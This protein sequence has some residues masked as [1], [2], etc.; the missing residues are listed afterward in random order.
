MTQIFNDDV[1][2]NGNVQV[3]GVVSQ[4][5]TAPS[6]SD[7]SWVHQGD[8]TASQ[9]V[10]GIH[11]HAPGK[12]TD[13]VRILKKA[14]PTA[15][16]TVTAH[17]E[18]LIHQIPHQAAGVL[19]RSSSSGRHVNFGITNSGTYGFSLIHSRWNSY[20]NWANNIFGLTV[21]A[22]ISW[23]RLEDDGTDRNCYVSIDGENWLLISSTANTDHITPDEVGF[24]VTPT[25]DS[26]TTLPDAAILVTTW[27]EA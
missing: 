13:Y 20:T 7:F 16:Y 5:T 23:F 18:M 14:A 8:A 15:P 4:Q 27:E 9:T 26:N 19:W 3:S 24:Y 1:E 11:V 25:D 21:P 6:L 22:P 17:I 12:H 10:R 2:V